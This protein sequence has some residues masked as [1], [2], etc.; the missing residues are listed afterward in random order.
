MPKV[1]YLPAG[2]PVTLTFVNPA[3]I[4]HT[5]TARSFFA[6]SR[7]LS[8]PVTRGEVNL[9]S[10]R[11]AAVQLVPAAGRYTLHC[12]IFLHRPLGMKGTIIV[13]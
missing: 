3:G 12:R 9:R 6:A 1:L 7:I 13:Q 10:R 8:G 4:S 11:S 2:R 5:F